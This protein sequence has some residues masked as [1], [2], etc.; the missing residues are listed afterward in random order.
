MASER[1]HLRLVATTSIPSETKDRP[2]SFA[3]WIYSLIVGCAALIAG[4]TLA[5]IIGLDGS[6]RLVVVAGT[7]VILCA[8]AGLMADGVLSRLSRKARPPG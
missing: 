3:Q 8:V 4:Q 6:A 1:R 5:A 2:S 7:V